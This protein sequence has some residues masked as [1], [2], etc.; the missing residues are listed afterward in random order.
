MVCCHAGREQAG[1]QLCVRG[2]VSLGIRAHKPGMEDQEHAFEKDVVHG[3]RY[4]EAVD[5]K[6]DLEL[7][8][9]E[10]LVQKDHLYQG[11]FL[12]HILDTLLV[13]FVVELWDLRSLP[14]EGYG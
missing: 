7:V 12:E 2:L 8:W 13:S 9:K 14:S 4:R 11:V 6:G 10:K 3:R 5:V 1:D